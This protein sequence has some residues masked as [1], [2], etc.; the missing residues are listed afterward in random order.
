MDLLVNETVVN[1]HIFS[2]TAK[3]IQAYENTKV[4]MKMRARMAKP[5]LP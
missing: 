5:R 3:K 2:A 1:N 4:A